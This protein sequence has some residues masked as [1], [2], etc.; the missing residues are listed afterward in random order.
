MTCDNLARRAACDQTGSFGAL[1]DL[2]G[3]KNKNG[4]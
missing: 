4:N 2:L 3:Q 1:V